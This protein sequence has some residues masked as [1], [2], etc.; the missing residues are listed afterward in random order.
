MCLGKPNLFK[1]SLAP[2]GSGQTEENVFQQEKITAR[3]AVYT[4]RKT[5]A[6]SPYHA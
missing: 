2:T 4:Y 3:P 1:K 6:L 5:P